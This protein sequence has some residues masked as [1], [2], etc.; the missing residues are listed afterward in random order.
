MEKHIGRN[1]IL[2]EEIHHLDA[3]RGNN[4]INNLMLFPDHKSHMQFHLETKRIRN[5]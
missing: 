4:N 1:I 3:D 2:P 5:I